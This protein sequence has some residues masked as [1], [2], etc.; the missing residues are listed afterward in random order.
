M[1]PIIDVHTHV[2]RGKDIPLKGYL[3]SRRYD[4]WYIKLL[5]PILFSIIARCIRRGGGERKGFLCGLMLGLVYKYMGEG[6]RRWSDIL[7]R[8]EISDITQRLIDTFDKDGIDLY[9]PLMIDY[10]YWFRSTPEPSIASQI[11][12]VYRDAVLPFRGRI[13]PFAPFD[14]ARELAYRHGLPGPDDVSAE[15]YSSLELVKDAIRNKGFIGVKV[16]NTLG[17]RPL[18]NTAVDKKRQRI[19]RRNKMEQYSVFTGEEF[20]QVLAELYT[21]C[22]HEQVPITAHCVYNGIEAYP[23]ASFDF[24]HPAYWR[25]V[26]DEFEGLHVNLAHFGWSRPEEYLAA[27]IRPSIIAQ[28][29]RR[30]TQARERLEQSVEQ[31]SLRAL[32]APARDEDKTAW[33]S[34][35]CEMLTEYDDLYADVAH[36]SVTEEKNIEK[37]KT[38]YRAMCRDFPGVVQRKLLF[39]IDWHVIARVGGFEGFKAGCERILD[40]DAILTSTELDD[41][42]G[43]NALRFLGLLPLGTPPAEGWTKNRERLQRFYRDNAIEPPEWFTATA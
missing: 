15:K 36:H 5:A 23:G 11:D 18:G 31:R 26:L 2:F 10:E 1:K 33:V 7:S 21:F 22:L 12:M 6:Y 35:I 13:H 3:L 14:P 16:Y 40:D 4:E 19:F 39:G 8:Q 38:A 43:G 41:F 42:F 17:Y 37:Y 27:E 32:A 30:L 25:A 29:V 28:A 9:I 34:V 20:D 24:G